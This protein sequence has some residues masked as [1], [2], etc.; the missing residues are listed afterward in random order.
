MMDYKLRASRGTMTVIRA[1]SSADEVY[2]KACKL[3][4]EG[5]HSIE[6]TTPDGLVLLQNDLSTLVE[7]QK[8]KKPGRR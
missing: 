3:I 8:K 6:V 4:E 5:Y 7:E 2:E 1:I